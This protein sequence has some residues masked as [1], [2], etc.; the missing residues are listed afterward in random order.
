MRKY[1]LGMLVLFLCGPLSPAAIKRYSVEEFFKDPQFSGFTLS[2]NGKKMLAIAP[3]PGAD[4]FRNIFVIDVEKLRGGQFEIVPLTAAKRHIINIGWFSDDRI[5]YGM[6]DRGVD[7]AGLWAVD[8]DGDN[9]RELAKPFIPQERKVFRYTSVLDPME[10]DDRFCLVVSNERRLNYPDVYIMDKVRGGKK[11]KVMNPGH[12]VSW[13]PD[14]DAVV[15]IGLEQDPNT[16]A[17]TILYRED[18]DSEWEELEVYDDPDTSMLPITFLP[19]NRTLLVA[20]NLDSDTRGMYKYD[21]KTRKITGKVFQH[22]EYD[23]GGPLIHRKTDEL[24][25]VSYVGEKPEIVYMD[26]KYKE[27]QEMLDEAIPGYI[28]RIASIDENDEFAIIYSTSDRQ[29]G[30]FFQFDI[31]NLSLR[32]L[33]RPR[34]W[35]DERDMA[36]MRPITFTARDGMEIPGYLSLPKTYNG[37]PV[38]L[39]AMP[40]GGPWARDVW[41]FDPWVQYLCNRGFAVLKINF[42]G[43]TGYGTEF[44]KASFKNVEAMNNDV[45]D[46]VNWA[47]EQGYADPDRLGV[48]G[49]S[50]GGYATMAQLALH[51]DKYDFGVN[52]F[53][54]VDLVE[55]INT[56]RGKWNRDPAFRVWQRR[57]GDPD[58]DEERAELD[59]MSAIN[60]IDKIDVPVF[61]YHGLQDI[62]V[63]I[64]QSRM[65]AGALSRG[66]ND[67]VTVY[68]TDEAHS[69]SLQENRLDIWTQIEEFLQ[70]FMPRTA[71]SM[72]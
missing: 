67:P 12:V 3:H 13:L 53:G 17:I 10:E 29:P 25:G 24:L 42:R 19:D 44:Y 48:L 32:E 43:S 45:T 5:Y 70:P 11:I 40:H 18:E 33:A 61:I 31:K 35:I 37:R 26:P 58:V 68:K 47:I 54:V 23:V 2:P 49:A 36:E 46:G 69:M 28:N 39:I 51:P 55:H 65:L 16:D 62:N 57:I 72:N 22:P 15:R 64:G 30:I 71:L 38:P 1:L 6:L 63:D 52:I 20:S 14:H 9:Y 8:I 60:H 4:G 56:Y 41:G 27:I 59:R 50:W 66:G 34:H 7:S 21:T